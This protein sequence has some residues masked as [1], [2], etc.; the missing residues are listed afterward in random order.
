M[1]ERG[2]VVT[3]CINA[4]FEYARTNLGEEE[5][6]HGRAEE[7][8]DAFCRG[9]RAVGGAERV[10]H[11]EIEGLRHLFGERDVVRR[12]LLV[13]GRLVGFCEMP[14]FVCANTRVEVLQI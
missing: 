4:L 2:S 8:G 14:F 9:V 5:A 1:W 12:L 6:T 13:R 7:T 3:A 11:E 10:V